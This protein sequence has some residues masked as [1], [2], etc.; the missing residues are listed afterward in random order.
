[1]SE[2]AVAIQETDPPQKK[3]S[4]SGII[5]LV[6]ILVILWFV[7]A[8]MR[9]PEAARM[10]LDLDEN[11][12]QALV[13]TDGQGQGGL[14]VSDSATDLAKKS[15]E[16]EA[17]KPMGQKD[18]WYTFYPNLNDERK[19]KIKVK[20][21]GE[22]TS[23][24]SVLVS[25]NAT[26]ADVRAGLAGLLPTGNKQNDDRIKKAIESIDDSLKAE[27]WSGPSTLTDKGK[28][29]DELRKF[30]GDSREQ[31]EGSYAKLSQDALKQAIE[32]LAA[33]VKPQLD[34][35]QKSI[36][37]TPD[38]K[39]KAIE[40]LLAPVREMIE[41]YRKQMEESEG[42]RNKALGGVKS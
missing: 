21:G 5:G 12:Q 29:V 36:G 4:K 20:D 37:T 2:P 13:L 26:K 16:Q 41:S 17:A 14:A 3:S 18:V 15:K 19:N 39:G 42:H 22:T 6:V 23:A 9:V 8:S 35:A 34:G 28:N 25:A 40:T 11:A 31:L 7:W 30:V 10:I 24:A 32:Q 33:V 1:M 38:E 27:Y